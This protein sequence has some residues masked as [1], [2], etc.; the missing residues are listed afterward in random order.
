MCLE[1]EDGSVELDFSQLDQP[2]EGLFTEGCFALVEGDYTED[3]TLVVIAIGHPP[4]ENRESARSMFGHVDFLGQGA[5]SLQEDAQFEARIQ[6]DLPDLRFFVLSDVWLDVPDTFVGIRKMLDNC[7]ENNFVPKMIVFCGDFT[8]KGIA[9]G[10]G[11]DM[12]KYQGT[13]ETIYSN[14]QRP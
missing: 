11:K 10:N 12:R 13:G 6:T 9:Q 2:S 4:C 1:D 8:G 14:V 5:T 3:A 7:I